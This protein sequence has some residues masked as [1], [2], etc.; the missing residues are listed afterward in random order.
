MSFHH[1][2]KKMTAAS[3]DEPEAAIILSVFLIKIGLVAIGSEQDIRHPVR[4]SA[5]LLA[6]HFQ[7]NSGVTF[8]DKFIVDVADDKAVAESLHS[9][10][11]DVTADGLDDILHELRFI[12]FDAQKAKMKEPLRTRNPWR[13]FLWERRWTDAKQTK[14]ALCLSG[15]SEP[16]RWSLLSG[17]SAE[18]QQ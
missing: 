1:S 11:E 7:I 8:D 5:H 13:L 3:G 2:L 17:A 12:G 15:L 6:D 10:A 4:G 9:I 18:G 14:E 16:Y